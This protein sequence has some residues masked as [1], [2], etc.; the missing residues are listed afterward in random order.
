VDALPR[1]RAFFDGQKPL[2]LP[3]LSE[4]DLSIL[5]SG[6]DRNASTV[7]FGAHQVILVRSTEAAARL[8]LALRTSALVMT[9]PQSKGL[10]FVRAQNS[11][12]SRFFA[13]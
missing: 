10:E 13:R 2:L 8:P 3:T 11:L 5:L 1:E 9:V 12:R 6:A 7:E 4:T